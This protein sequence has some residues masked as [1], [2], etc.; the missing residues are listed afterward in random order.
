M[1]PIF[2]LLLCAALVRGQQAYL[3]PADPVAMP[4]V[5]DSNSP[6]HRLRDGR[7]ALYNSDGTPVR[8]LG[9]DQFSLTDPEAI[10]WPVDLAWIESTWTAGD[11]VVYAWYHQERVIDCGELPSLSMPAIG[12][13]VSH[14]DGRNFVDLGLVLTAGQLPNCDARNGY[15]AGGHGDFTV[16]L[17]RERQYFYFYYST[18]GG[19]PASQG[20]ALA[21]MSF[22]DRDRPVVGKYADG[23]FA[24]PGLGGRATPLFPVSADWATSSP[25]AFWGPSVHWNT[26]L[27]RYVMLLNRAC[28][29]AGWPQEGVYIAYATDPTAWSEPSK[30]LDGGA[31]YPQVLGLEPSGTDKRAGREA[32]LYLSGLSEWTIR[33]ERH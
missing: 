26:Y 15:F 7:L 3:V 21:R 9:A 29:A 20:V 8:S 5:A 28:C 32:R 2:H 14:D 16:L 33:F 10:G 23:S 17:D 25:D 1:R 13:A 11:G 18:Y 24:E 27:Q 6:A 22:G 12:A 4:G 31:W 30:L 19:P